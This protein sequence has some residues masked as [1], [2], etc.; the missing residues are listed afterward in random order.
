MPHNQ[1]VLP[2]ATSEPEAPPL[3][4]WS[5]RRD[6]FRARLQAL[7]VAGESPEEVEAHCNLMPARY[8]ESVNDI[9]LPWGLET[10]HAFLETTAMSNTPPTNPYVSFREAPEGGF[11]RMMLSTW[12]RHGLLAKTA[13]AFSAARL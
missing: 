1:I 11:T 10:V 2:A 13:A 4:P 6:W 12:D 3:G 9:D 8:W 7:S 5:A